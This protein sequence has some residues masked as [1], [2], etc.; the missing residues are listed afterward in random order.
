MK[1]SRSLS[2]F[3]KMIIAV[4]GGAMLGIALQCLKL[5]WGSSSSAWQA[6]DWLLLVDITAAEGTQGLGLLNIVGSLFM[7]AM[8]LA[9]VPLVFTSLALAVEA[10]DDLGKLGRISR[11]M[12]LCFALFYI[13]CVVVA[14]SVALAVRSAGAFS[15]QLPA[16][17][18]AGG[19]KLSKVITHSR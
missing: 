8:Q 13:V 11:K 3:A 15:S 18:S 5:A 12:V 16:D 7:S 4:V 10:A 6:V 9:V 1:Q 2:L 17:I 14:Q 19:V